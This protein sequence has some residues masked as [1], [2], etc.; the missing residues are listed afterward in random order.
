VRSGAAQDGCHR[1][2]STESPEDG[3]TDGVEGP[4]G[5]H[6]DAAENGK[7][8]ITPALSPM[9]VSTHSAIEG[10]YGDAAAYYSGPGALWDF[11]WMVVTLIFA[12]KALTAGYFRQVIV[13]ADPRAW[14][15]LHRKLRLPE[16][17]LL[18]VYRG[19][20]FYALGRMISWF[21][22]ARFDAKTP[23]QPVWGGPLYVE[24]ADL[25]DA[26]FVEEGAPLFAG[27]ETST[28]RSTP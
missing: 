23:F 8:G 5:T 11:G 27:A 4:V 1:H 13:P 19:I 24:G 15:W 16:R 18:L 17:A 28:S 6:V 25:S 21:L 2:D 26:S 10:R 12:W 7:N 3:A 20:F 22:F 14:G 9:S